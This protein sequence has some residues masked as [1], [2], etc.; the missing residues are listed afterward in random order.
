MNGY[1]PEETFYYWPLPASY[2]TLILDPVV[3]IEEPQ[4]SLITAY[5]LLP[6]IR[7]LST[8][9]P[10]FIIGWQIPRP[11]Q[12]FLQFITLPVN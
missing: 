9:L 2:G 10:P 7:I 6:T 12:L 11:N 3:G 4:Q 1:W 8:H 5:E